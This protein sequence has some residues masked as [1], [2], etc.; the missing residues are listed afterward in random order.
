M[1]SKY[2]KWNYA[3]AIQN[4]VHIWGSIKCVKCVIYFLGQQKSND[5][6]KVFI[7]FVPIWRHFTSF[8]V[9]T[10]G[11]TRRHN[12][13]QNYV[14]FSVI[15]FRALCTEKSLTTFRLE[16]SF[17]SARAN[18]ERERGCVTTTEDGS[19]DPGSSL[20]NRNAPFYSPLPQ[21]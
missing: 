21:G 1:L 9:I 15:H 8:L 10:E 6:L 19:S 11:I 12:T 14:I 18:N 7:P 2:I 13:S 3:N 4:D 5:V 17:E 20:Q 16:I